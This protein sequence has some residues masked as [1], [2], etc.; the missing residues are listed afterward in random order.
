MSYEDHFTFSFHIPLIVRYLPRRL[1]FPSFF[2][3]YGA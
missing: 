2:K 1:I 3:E